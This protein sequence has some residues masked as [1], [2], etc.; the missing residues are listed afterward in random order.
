MILFICIFF[1]FFLTSY[2]ETK[3]LNSLFIVKNLKNIETLEEAILIRLHFKTSKA[4]MS[5]NPKVA[6]SL[7]PLLWNSWHIIQV[8]TS[9]V[10]LPTQINCSQWSSV[11]NILNCSLREVIL[12][13]VM[14]LDG[15]VY[16][17]LF[18]SSLL[19]N[20]LNVLNRLLTLSHLQKLHS[21]RL[22]SN[23]YFPWP[24]WNVWHFS[25]S[26]L[27]AI[28]LD[29]CMTVKPIC[30]VVSFFKYPQP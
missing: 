9:F 24:F 2:F 4:T 5:N 3:F 8:V 12:T 20:F 21:Q 17:I 16:G 29:S 23:Y 13:P 22:L 15:I 19:P 1:D 30:K 18:F 25:L 28:T 14:W 11:S 7:T 27:F 10:L 26:L 6:F